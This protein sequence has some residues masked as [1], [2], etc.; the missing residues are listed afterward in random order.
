MSEFAAG[1]RARHE[2]QEERQWCACRSADCRR[3]RAAV[4]SNAYAFRR[5]SSALRSNAAWL[6]V[7][8][9][10][11]MDRAG[12]GSLGLF[13]SK[14]CQPNVMLWAM[15]IRPSLRRLNVSACRTKQAKGFP[16]L[17]FLKSRSSGQHG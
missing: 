14:R 3:I 5:H 17:L 8:L 7:E 12:V 10:P 16:R 2:K 15:C 13:L 9:M 4:R 6:S 1:F 11:N